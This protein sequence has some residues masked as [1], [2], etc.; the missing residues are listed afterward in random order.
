MMKKA[1][2]LLVMV[3][4]FGFSNAYAHDQEEGDQVAGTVLVAGLAVITTAFLM[5]ALNRHDEYRPAPRHVQGRPYDRRDY[6]YSRPRDD[7]HDNGN[8]SGAR[9]NGEGYG[10]H[11][12]E[13]WEER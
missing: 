7:R 9:Y 4:L 5:A 8:H 6:D 12:G 10:W 3:A 13:R 2:T 1:I 11:N